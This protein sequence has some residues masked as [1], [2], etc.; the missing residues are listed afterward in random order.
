MKK[1]ILILLVLLTGAVCASSQT[2]LYKSYLKQ[3]GIRPSCIEDYPI[4]N[5]CSVTVTMLEAGQKSDFDKILKRMHRLLAYTDKS[6][7]EV[8]GKLL[9]DT[10]ST[11]TLDVEGL[12]LFLGSLSSISIEGSTDSNMANAKHLTF[13]RTRPKRG[14]SGFYLVWPSEETLTVLVFHCPNRAVYI[15]AVRYVLGKF[16]HS[17]K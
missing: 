12:M 3:K 13:F 9:S 17:I 6:G 14:D 10:D 7:F 11:D 8:I 16:Y 5:E 1:Q 4:G 2:A 15:Q